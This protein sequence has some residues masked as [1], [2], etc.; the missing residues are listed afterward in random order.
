[1][2]QSPL[3]TVLPPIE[4]S[5]GIFRYPTGSYRGDPFSE[6]S[7]SNLGI[8]HAPNYGGDATINN[9]YN[10]D[11][12]MQDIAGSG[13]F[14]VTLP[15]SVLP[16]DQFRYLDTEQAV[17]NVKRVFPPGFPSPDRVSAETDLEIHFQRGMTSGSVNLNEFF[18]RR[19]VGD[20]S[21]IYLDVNK[22][23]GG[24]GPAIIRPDYT[25]DPLNE[26]AESIVLDLTE[27]GLIEE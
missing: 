2:F 3:P 1:M 4:G 25:T 6:I 13:F 15:W 7:S 27:R 19:F 26:S 17:Y 24:T 22:P 18:M 20:S 11:Y 21:W 9:F 23:A 8:I 12:K 14:P 16:G 5:E 10:S